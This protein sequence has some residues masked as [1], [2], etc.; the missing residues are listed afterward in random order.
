MR[1]ARRDISG[2]LSKA[3]TTK[4][5]FVFSQSLLLLARKQLKA[6]HCK[7]YIVSSSESEMSEI[8][9]DLAVT[10]CSF[11]EQH[12]NMAVTLL[13]TKKLIV[14]EV[15]IPPT[16][17]SNDGLIQLKQVEDDFCVLMKQEVQDINVHTRQVIIT[18]FCPS[19]VKNAHSSVV[20]ILKL[21]TEQ[22]V[23]LECTPEE[24]IYLCKVDKECES[25]LS[26][27]PV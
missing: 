17:M 9:N 12:H 8:V 15:S 26:S 16:I 6:D 27:L 13:Q 3:I 18:G 23:K 4:I 14:K 21:Y 19:R 25:I 10:V 11:D 1:A 7:A 5:Q 22:H 2:L 24:V 20:D